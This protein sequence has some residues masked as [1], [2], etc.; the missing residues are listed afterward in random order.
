[1]KITGEVEKIMEERFGRDNVIALATVEGDMP[2]VRYVNAFYEQGAFYVITYGLSNKMRQLE[3]NPQAAI[4]GDW[5]TAR[6]R[7]RDLGY[8]GEAGNAETADKLRQAFSAWI[9]DGHNDFQD[10]NTRIL[11]IRLENGVLF[12]NGTRYDIDF[13]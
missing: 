12:S 6:G 11:Q 7:G 9:D 2:C 10:E 5:F 4:A 8:W 1:M 13:T 3:K